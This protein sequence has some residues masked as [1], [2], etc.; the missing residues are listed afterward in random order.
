MGKK[1]IGNI[2]V[3]VT[4]LRKVHAEKLWLMWK[5]LGWNQAKLKRESGISAYLIRSFCQY[6]RIK[7]RIGAR[8]AITIIGGLIEKADL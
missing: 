1:Q 5:D 8:L 7:L 4:R 3:S 6:K 2:P